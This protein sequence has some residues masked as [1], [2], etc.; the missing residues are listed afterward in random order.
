MFSKPD[1]TEFWFILSHNNAVVA[2]SGSFFTDRYTHPDITDDTP[3]QWV[4]LAIGG[5]T[6]LYQWTNLV[7]YDHTLLLLE[8]GK[9]TSG[10]FLIKFLAISTVD[11]HFVYR[12]S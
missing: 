2:V 12:V 7:L 1:D 4:H 6:Q 8:A 10:Q 5:S 11:R 9:A 3:G